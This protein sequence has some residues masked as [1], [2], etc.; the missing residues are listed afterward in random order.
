MKRLRSQKRIEADSKLLNII[1][2]IKK[3]HP[4]WGY[5]RVWAYLRFRKS[6]LVG[7]NRVYRIMQE[8]NLL[9]D[10]NNRNIARRNVTHSKP[11]AIYSNQFWGIDMTKIRLPHGWVY[12]HAIIDWFDKEVIGYYLSHRSQ[13]QDWLT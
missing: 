5:R 9:L 8:N 6:H 13:S 4:L 2:A 12:F 1:S 11:K 10:K 3:E 7:K